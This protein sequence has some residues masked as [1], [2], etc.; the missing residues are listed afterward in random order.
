M[1]KAVISHIFEPFFT[2]KEIKGTGLGLST[3]YGIVR[4]HEGFIG[5]ESNLG[6]GSSFYIFI[7]QIVNVTSPAQ[8]KSSYFPLPGGSETI[9]VVEDDPLVR[10]ISIRMLKELGYKLLEAGSGPE[11]LKILKDPERHINLLLTDVI[12]PKMDGTS[13]AKNA[14]KIRPD[15]KILYVTGYPYSYLSGKIGNLDE[16][17]LLHKPFTI[18]DVAMKIRKVIDE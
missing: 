12:M 9:L 8:T 3:V 10:N 13:L 4:Q 2:T 1:D 17:N 7:P 15:L 16:R 18:E 11:A 5:V 14:R 6:K